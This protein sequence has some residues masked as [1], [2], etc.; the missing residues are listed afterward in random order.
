MNLLG[1]GTR[2]AFVAAATGVAADHSILAT[3]ITGAFALAAVIVG[4]LVTD[5]LRNR[6]SYIDHITEAT[7]EHADLS[8]RLLDQLEVKD[9]EIAKLRAENDQLKR[10]HD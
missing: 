6:R 4:P 2:G 10:R 3:I 9:A 7:A 8:E 1:G 5:R